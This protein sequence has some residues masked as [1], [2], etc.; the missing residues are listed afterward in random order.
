[1]RK[2]QA[3]GEATE[4]WLVPG[5]RKHPIG[6]HNKYRFGLWKRSRGGGLYRCSSYQSIFPLKPNTIYVS[7]FHLSKLRSFLAGMHSNLLQCKKN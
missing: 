1:M 3:E 2:L 6:I 5:N 4:A 7:R